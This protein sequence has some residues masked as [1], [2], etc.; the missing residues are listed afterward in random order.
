MLATASIR[1]FLPF[2]LCLLGAG[3]CASAAQ[4]QSEDA[5]PDVAIQP[6][7]QLELANPVT[8]GL[9]DQRVALTGWYGSPSPRAAA[10]GLGL[11]VPAYSPLAGWYGRMPS[12]DLGVRWRSADDGVGRVDLGLWQRI[13]P[14]APSLAQQI[15][16][17][18]SFAP[19]LEMQFSTASARGIR[20][21][22]GGALGMQLNPNERVVLRLSKG[23][24]MVYYRVRF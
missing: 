10:W 1:A 22:L 23:R 5:S 4:A 8:L 2:W 20:F 6:V 11:S 18:R 19:R 7:L 3:V 9:Q 14:D 17:Q 12:T 16:V 21:E 24:T 15:A 13:T